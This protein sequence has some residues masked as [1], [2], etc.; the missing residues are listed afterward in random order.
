MF[1]SR[2]M[3][4]RATYNRHAGKLL[5][6]PRFCTE[7]RQELVTNSSTSWASRNDGGQ[8]TR[9]VH[10]HAVRAHDVTDCTQGISFIQ[11]GENAPTRYHL[12]GTHLRI[13]LGGEIQV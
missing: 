2:V 5:V 11:Q 9:T 12:Q 8:Y 10:Y 4:L 3:L 6:C 1:I 7:R 13:A